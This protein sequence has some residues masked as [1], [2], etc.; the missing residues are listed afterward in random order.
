MTQITENWLQPDITRNKYSLL[1][2]AIIVSTIHQLL[3]NMYP[4]QL[5]NF[6]HF[7]GGRDIKIILV[8]LMLFSIAS[9]LKQTLLIWLLSCHRPFNIIGEMCSFR[10]A[11]Y[12]QLAIHKRFN[13][14]GDMGSFRHAHYHQL[15]MHRPFNILYE[16][17]S[18]RHAHYQP[19]ICPLTLQ[20]R[21]V[22]LDMHITISQQ[23][24]CPLTLQ[25][26]RVAIDMHI[27][28]SQ[29][30]IGPLTL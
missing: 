11:Y 2:C 4:C 27:T 13:V 15:A 23:C 28:I 24:I 21:S 17:V 22:A 7:R 18:F 19:C 12:H 20:V 8:L 14:I 9:E 6:H 26:R 1:H 30:F 29:P 5:Y 3:S 10:Y 25:V 16:T